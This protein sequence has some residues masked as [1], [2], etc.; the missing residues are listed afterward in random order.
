MQA[1]SLPDNFCYGVAVVEAVGP[2]A[3]V[4]PTIFADGDA[5]LFGAKGKNQLAARGLKVAR[6]VEDIVR[7]EEHFALLEKN[8]AVGDECCGVGY[9]FAGFVHGVAYESHERW[10]RDRFG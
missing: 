2:E 6:F 1:T 9:G 3:F 10:E 5:E 8:F 4:V 7:G